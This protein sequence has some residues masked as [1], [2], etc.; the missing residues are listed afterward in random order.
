MSWQQRAGPPSRILVIVAVASLAGCAADPSKPTDAAMTCEQIADEIARQDASEKISEARA[1]ELRARYYAYQA[2]TL[3][4]IVGD[5][6]ALGDMATDVSRGRELDHLNE[7]SRTARNRREHLTKLQASRC[8][9][10][11]AHGRNS[12]RVYT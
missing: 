8:P 9:K 3:V 1:R 11:A 12:R 2:A 7:D 5:V 4:P 6:L 10:V